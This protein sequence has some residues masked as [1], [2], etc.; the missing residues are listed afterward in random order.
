MVMTIV[1]V[2]YP[3]LVY[4]GLKVFSPLVMG[5]ALI[6]FLFMRCVFQLADRKN[7]LELAAL[8]LSATCI[9]VLLATDAHLAVKAYPITI[10]L[11]L[12][13]V[14]A[15]SLFF[16]PCIIE[17]FARLIEPNLNDR[18]VRY[19]RNVTLIWICFFLVNSVISG[20]LALYASLEHWTLYNGLIAYI[21]VGILFAGELAVR[22]FVKK[23]H[24]SQR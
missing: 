20:W 19:T 15:Y 3:F 24:V 17:R 21:L 18:G 23:G 9:V 16:P 22:Q 6:V 7:N 5:I 8:G 1:G 14:F 4:F 10:N 2:A 11:G 12:A 13:S